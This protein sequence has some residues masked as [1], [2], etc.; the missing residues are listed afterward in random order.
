MAK[1]KTERE[2]EAEKANGETEVK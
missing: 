1:Q 2:T